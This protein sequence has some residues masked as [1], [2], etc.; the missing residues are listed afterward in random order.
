MGVRGWVAEGG[1]GRKRYSMRRIA[2]IRR[3]GTEAVRAVTAL[4]AALNSLLGRL[5][6]TGR[7]VPRA[8]RDAAA[9]PGSELAGALLID[10]SPS[11][12]FGDQPFK[13]E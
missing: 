13:R 3:K 6:K 1:R 5:I 10:E 4:P 2:L 11:I 12:L 8:D 9:I 7:P